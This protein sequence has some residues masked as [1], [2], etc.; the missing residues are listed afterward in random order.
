MSMSGGPVPLRCQE[1]F[2]QQV[3]ADGFDRGDPQR[4]ADGAVRG[5]APT[6]GEDPLSGAEVDELVDDEEVAGEVQVDDHSQLVV[7]LRPR[8][9]DLLGPLRR[10][11]RS[12]ALPTLNLHQLHQPAG[13]VVPGRHREGRQV[14]GQ[15]AQVQGAVP[16]GPR[17]LRDGSRIAGQQLGHLLPAAQMGGTGG[18]VRVRLGERHPG[19]QGG[20]S[21]REALV[22]GEGVV[23]VGAGHQRQG[24]ISSR[25][26]LSRTRRAPWASASCS[27]SASPPPATSSTATLPGP[28][29]STR[30]VMASAAA[31]AAASRSPLSR[32]GAAARVTE[33]LRQPVRICQCP[34]RAR[35]ESS[36]SR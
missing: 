7:D 11:A 35:R 22:G 31:W 26:W 27:S 18:E 15:Q 6:L 25:S 19:A 29:S 10:R 9:G 21:V 33:P 8:P 3:V 34:S 13:L 14:R 1:A 23:G 24:R 28:N 32:S 17:R 2:E 16:A 4:V 5:R 20:V 12:V 36:A 30:R